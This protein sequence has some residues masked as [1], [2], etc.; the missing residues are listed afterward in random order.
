MT[1]LI[2]HMN[3][4]TKHCI[5]SSTNSGCGGQDVWVKLPP[6]HFLAVWLGP[7]PLLSRVI[8]ILSK[9]RIFF[10][11]GFLRLFSIPFSGILRDS[12]TC[13]NTSWS[14]SQKCEPTVALN[15]K[16]KKLMKLST[17]TKEKPT[18]KPPWS[19]RYPREEQGREEVQVIS[20]VCRGRNYMADSGV[21]RNQEALAICCSPKLK[22]HSSERS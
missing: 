19:W 7:P 4:D 17:H 9:W 11:R 18:A 14:K 1:H 15:L 5:R 10:F 13:C 21:T 12:N 22:E 16:F 6:S 20:P 3:G 8:F 2:S